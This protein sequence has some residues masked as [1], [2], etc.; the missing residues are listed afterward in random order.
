[1]ADDA[2]DGVIQRI[3][4]VLDELEAERFKR[5]AQSALADGVKPPP[6]TNSQWDTVMDGLKK[7]AIQLGG[8]IAAAFA[9]QKI[10]QFTRESVHA[11]IESRGAWAELTRVLSGVGIEYRDVADEVDRLA[12][13]MAASNVDDEKTAEILATLTLQS[14]DYAAALNNVQL[15]ADLAAAKHMDVSAAAEVVGKSLA[16]NN[17][18]LERMFPN[19]KDNA[20]ALDILRER[21][22][23]T[24][25]DVSAS[26]GG[27]D[28]LAIAWGNMKESFGEAVIAMFGGGET[29]G[30]IT[31]LVKSFTDTI[32]ANRDGLADLGKIIVW[33]VK[34]AI[35]SL[36]GA[37]AMM[38]KTG[39]WV[40][41]SYA[42][43]VLGIRALA[44]AAG[45]ATPG[46]DKHIEKLE[47]L[48]DTLD[49][50]ARAANQFALVLTG[51]AKPTSG[52]GSGKKGGA[53]AGGGLGTEPPP[54]G[55]APGDQPKTTDPDEAERERLE[56]LQRAAQVSSTRAAALAE[57]AQ[58]E[59]DLERKLEDGNLTLEKRVELEE[60]LRD[61]R[62]ALGKDT[63]DAAAYM[64][65]SVSEAFHKLIEG[66]G[67][68][69]DSFK[70]IL[71]DIGEL[72]NAMQLLGE[73]NWKGIVRGIQK[74]AKVEALRAAAKA[75]WEGAQALAALAT[76]NPGQAA[77]HGK[78]AAGYLVSMAKWGAVAGGAAIAGGGGSSGGGGGA[79]AS[80]AGVG[81]DTVDSAERRGG[82][83]YLQIDG[84]DP[85]RS[86]H[87]LLVGDTVRAYYERTGGGRVILNGR[88]VPV[89]GAR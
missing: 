77:T 10:I 65:T 16:G 64:E 12:D 30:G 48:I 36:L 76:G 32:D 34:V 89:G 80:V 68:I 7:K 22:K 40:V 6:R 63:A 54:A 33:L 51:R 53:G 52:T 13:R 42:G 11:A 24:A 50:G 57:L 83:L 71:H 55:G 27:V 85:D 46:L 28:Q 88:E 74:E 29:I 69:G 47:N 37:F 59:V 44:Q 72:D 38:I 31:S 3:R 43:M 67:S 73:G 15:V 87:Q 75:A 23:G 45:I 81:R 60:Q 78:A 58:A 9:V 41:Q 8:A 18:L 25:E 20:N 2:G 14:R 56:L 70:M 17:A 84:V 21:L 39:S 1:M 4:L 19:L 62:L 49:D 5:E 26:R 61:V 35:G 66:G 86:R 79:P 82:D